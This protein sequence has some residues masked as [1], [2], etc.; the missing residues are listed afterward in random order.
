MDGEVMSDNSFF[1]PTL[2]YKEFMILDLIEK[3]PHIT[4]REIASQI[5][6]AVSMVNQYLDNYEKNGLIKRKKHSTKTVEYFVTKKGI[7]RKKLLNINYLNDSLKVF[8]SAKKNIVIFI[9]QILEKG[10]KNI[11]LYGAGEVA[12]ILLQA[13]VI[14][15]DIKLN[16]LGVIDDDVKKQNLTLLNSNI[17]S[18]SKALTTQFDGIFISSYTNNESIFNKLMN[19]NVNQTK[20][21]QFFD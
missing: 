5:G 8:K 3:D 20:I 2:L 4:Q 15:K 18:L 21:I 10:Y 1:K 9:N 13:I 16:I 7:E 19:N 6:V 17:I 14:D 11:Y 12:E